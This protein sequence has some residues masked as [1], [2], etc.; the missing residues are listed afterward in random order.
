MH[1]FKNNEPS[2]KDVSRQNQ[3]SVINGLSFAELA[4][5][6]SLF[7]AKIKRE[8]VGFVPVYQIF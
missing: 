1:V 2:I 5:Q 3:K 6:R 7:K 8:R 4:S